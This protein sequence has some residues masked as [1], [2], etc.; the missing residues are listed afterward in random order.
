VELAT[1]EDRDS[2]SA[3]C[4][5]VAEDWK[6]PMQ[7]AQANIKERQAQLQYWSPFAGTVGSIR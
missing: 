6:K 5:A 2:S 3:S 4:L 7:E 1:T